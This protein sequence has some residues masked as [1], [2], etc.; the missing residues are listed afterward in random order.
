M[1][2]RKVDGGPSRRVNGRAPTRPPPAQHPQRL[3]H[4][5]DPHVHRRHE[6]EVRRHPAEGTVVARPTQAVDLGGEG[7]GEQE[8]DAEAEPG[9]VLTLPSADGPGT[10]GATRRG[11]RARAGGVGPRRR[12]G[13]SRWCTAPTSRARP[14]SVDGFDA[15]VV[16]GGP[17]RP[18]PT[19]A[20]RPAR[21]ELGAARR[22]RG[23]RPAGA[24]VCLGAQLLAEATGGRAVRG[25]A[26]L[27]VGLGRGHPHPGRRRRRP[28]RRRAGLRSP[29]CTGTATPSSSP[30]RRAA[31]VERALPEPGLPGGAP[32]V[33]HP[34]P[35]RGRPGPG[36][37]VRRRVARRRPTTST[38][39]P[40]ASS[41]RPTTGSPR[42]PR[43]P[44]PILGR[45]ASTASGDGG[46]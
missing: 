30:R 39:G 14:P 31:G 11:R 4:V 24:G 41:P 42:S 44:A 1:S 10:G 33:G 23:P 7:L 46:R 6:G 17:S 35:R 36:R 22:R 20:S 16:M 27:E 15:L 28:L 26:G 40:P 29:R 5:V 9:H 18:T 34:V 32:G 37:G 12:P 38:A 45:F 25:E 3:G 2:G 13:S 43:S 8:G 21:A 19:T